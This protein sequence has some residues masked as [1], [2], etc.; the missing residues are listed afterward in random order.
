MSEVIYDRNAA[1][2]NTIIY[3]IALLLALAALVTRKGVLRYIFVG[4][5]VLWQLE[6]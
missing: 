2:R 5:V 6:A 4:I 3:A 1:I